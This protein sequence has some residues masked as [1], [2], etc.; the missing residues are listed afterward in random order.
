MVRINL[1]PIRDI[2]RKRELKQ[3]LF[4]V[5]AAL[6]V[7][8][9][10]GAGTYLYFNMVRNSLAE[11]KAAHDTQLADLKE[12]NKEIAI[13]KQEITRL[14]KQVDT[15]QKLTKV[16]DTPAPFMAAL[17]HA[18][19]DEV[20]LSSISKTGKSFSL[21]GTGVDNTV[22]VNFVERL[23]KVRDGFTEQRP[24]IDPRNQK[25]V[26]FFTDV[27]LISIVAGGGRGGLGG[28]TFKIVG[29]LR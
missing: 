11:E 9:L 23:Q 16:R 3:F 8:I 22:V 24:W 19:P 25:E 15:I 29:N 26:G 14:Q 18:I 12:K 4:L 20:W 21:D 28:V 27:K 5:G 1:L 2:L 10:V 17:S 7:T 13:L 6:V